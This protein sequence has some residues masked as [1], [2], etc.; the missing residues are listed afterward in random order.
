MNHS[1][2][3]WANHD[4]PPVTTSRS[5]LGMRVDA[6]SYQDATERITAWARRGESRS[7]CVAAV[8]NVMEAHDDPVFL[9]AMNSADLVTPDGMPLVWGLRLLGVAQAS[10][11]Y[12]PEL[13]PML[14]ARA[15]T[16]A[17]PVGFYGGTTD[18]LRDLVAV[19]HARMPGI[20]IAYAYSPPFGEIKPEDD[21]RIVQTINGSGTRI[22]FVG[23]GCPKQELW[24]A[25]HRDRVH[26]V[27]IGV[28]AAFDFLTGRKRQA[29]PTLQAAGL[30]W[31]FR[32]ATEP[33]RLWRRYLGQNPRFAVLFSAQVLSVRLGGQRRSLP[34]QEL[35]QEGER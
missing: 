21:A 33:K 14:L 26:S 10:R 9:R 22:L 16:E 30:E 2:D 5:I 6:T 19:A 23:L 17:L 20:Q 29:P 32:L 31:L 11:V 24:M 12:G 34:S 28:G 27:M 4:G 13:T 18:V 35:E 1:Q 7:V 25:S 8:N 3:P 15:R